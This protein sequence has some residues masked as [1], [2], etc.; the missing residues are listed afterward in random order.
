MLNW[1]M[2][3]NSFKNLSCCEKGSWFKSAVLPAG[4]LSPSAVQGARPG[5]GCDSAAGKQPG[6][7]AEGTARPGGTGAAVGSTSCWPVTLD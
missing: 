2:E 6:S 5:L 4:R 3:L 1:F 7:P